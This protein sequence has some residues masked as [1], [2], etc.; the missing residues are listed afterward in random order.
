MTR[1][2]AALVVV[3]AS[4]AYLAL[5]V[6]DREAALNV[7]LVYIAIVVTFLFAAQYRRHGG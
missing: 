5:A 4:V 7:I 6:V 3:C 2:H 1:L